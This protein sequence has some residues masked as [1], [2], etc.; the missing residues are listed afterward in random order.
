MKNTA[1][2]IVRKGSSHKTCKNLPK[3][4]RYSAAK[5]HVMPSWVKHFMKQIKGLK[6]LLEKFAVW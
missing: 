3:V 4:Y 1:E 6:R 5:C 2:M